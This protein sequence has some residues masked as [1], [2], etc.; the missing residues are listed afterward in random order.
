[1]QKYEFTKETQEFFG[2][3]LHRIVATRNFGDVKKGDLGGFIETE[4]NLSH[5]GFCWVFGEALVF[6]NARVSDN[7][8]VSGDAWVC[9]NALVCRL[10]LT[11]SHWLQTFQ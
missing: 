10:L 2:R 11:L 1:M 9:G 6:E 5:D 3:T 7:A 8:R 4:G